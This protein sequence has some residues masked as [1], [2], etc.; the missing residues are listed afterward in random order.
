MT[1][2]SILKWLLFISEVVIAVPIL[3]LQIISASA[4]LTAKKRKN[5]DT[6]SSAGFNFAILVPAHNEEGILSNLLESLA[7]LAYPKNQYTVFVVADNCTDS[8]AEIARTGGWV[9]VYERFDTIKRGKGYALNWL[10]QKLEEDELIYDA[11]IVLDADSVVM[12]N[13]LQAMAR[14][15]ARGGQALQANNTVLNA[16]DSPSAALRL[17]SMTLINYVR[18][19]G[20]NGLGAS[21]TLLGN[22]MCLSHAILKRYPWQAF[23]IAEDYQYYLTLVQHGERVRYVPDAVTRSL[24]PTTFTQMRTQ[25]VRWESGFSSWTIWQITF[26]LLSDGLKLRDFVRVEAAAEL[27]TPPL[28]VIVVWCSLTFIAA[29]LLYSLPE[30][31]IS[32][33]LIVGLI[34]Y[35][36]TGFYFLRPSRRLYT[37]LL[38]APGFIAWKL[39]VCFVL[40]RSKKHTSEWVRT[41]RII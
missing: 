32:V 25:D 33:F 12:P 21:S 13:F 29:M 24:M 4:I 10:L 26:K 23:G 7:K 20:R 37:A 36:G 1:T 3:Y 17:F 38:Y 27:L 19:L 41:S 18:P 39:W 9:R 40:S 22:G 16:F 2:L 8:T 11:Y 5:E 30:L 31:L 15:L 6:G 34:S 28:S 35:V 14:E